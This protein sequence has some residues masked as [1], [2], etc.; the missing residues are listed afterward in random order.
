MQHNSLTGI[1]SALFQ[2]AGKAGNQLKSIAGGIQV[3]DA[4]GTALVNLSAAH[5]SGTVPEQVVTRQDLGDS[6]SLIEG[7]FDGASPPSPGANTG[8][9]LVC[10]T[11]GGAYSAGE[12]YHDTGTT[13]R[14]LVTE[15][16][17][18]IV[19]AVAV[20]G[21]V[22]LENDSVYTAESGTAPFTWTKKGDALG[23]TI[24]VVSTIAVSATTAA[25]TASTEIPPAGSEIGVCYAVITTAY[26]NSA[27][28]TLYLDGTADLAIGTISAADAAIGGRFD[29]AP[30]DPF[31]VAGNTGAVTVDIS[32]TPTTGAVEM[33]VEYSENQRV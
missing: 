32:N 1:A 6:S 11:T 16:G 23:A 31:V 13:L 12:V 29:F 24:G 19:T 4:A 8:K 3:L 25:S 17:W 15:K 21:T 27:A 2:L 7:S 28:L 26:D 9:K 33:H 22:V 10:H 30:E 5:S 18:S 20:N 14:L